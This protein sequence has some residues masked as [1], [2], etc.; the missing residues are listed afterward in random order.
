MDG[1]VQAVKIPRLLSPLSIN[2]F[3]GV[4]QIQHNY[5][6]KVICQYLTL[7]ENPVVKD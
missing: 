2:V 6:V 7:V 1:G 4:S 5:E 3:V